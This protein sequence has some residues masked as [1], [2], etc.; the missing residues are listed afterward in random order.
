MN[1]FCR[2]PSLYLIDVTWS[3]GSEHLCHLPVMSM[4]TVGWFHAR[5]CVLYCNVFPFHWW[6]CCR[7]N[8]APTLPP[9]VT[10]SASAYCVYFAVNRLKIFLHNGINIIQ[11]SVKSAS[12]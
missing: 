11:A 5:A 8:N 4:E 7:H 2:I 1:A 9:L 3:R 6:Q 12:E 10:F